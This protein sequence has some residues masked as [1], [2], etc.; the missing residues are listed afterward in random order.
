LGVIPASAFWKYQKVRWA[1]GISIAAVRDE[2]LAPKPLNLAGLFEK[3]F[4]LN[5]K[6]PLIIL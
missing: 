2:R 3:L 6:L 1:D 5:L 4:P